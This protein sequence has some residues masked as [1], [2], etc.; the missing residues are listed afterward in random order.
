[1]ARPHSNDTPTRFINNAR[2][3]RIQTLC[4]KV[5]HDRMDSLQN[6][7]EA[8]GE[9]GKQTHVSSLGML[10]VFQ[11]SD[12]AP[13]MHALT[14]YVHRKTKPQTVDGPILLGPLQPVSRPAARTGQP[15]AY[16]LSKSLWQNIM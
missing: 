11:M 10:S 6:V 8:P 12:T 9:A 13:S 4:G 2:A 7:M 16:K 1:V 5:Q 3:A 15:R 14:D